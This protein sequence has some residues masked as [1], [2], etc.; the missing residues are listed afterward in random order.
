MYIKLIYA[1]MILALALTLIQCGGTED[2]TTEGDENSSSSEVE[3]AQTTTTGSTE[4]DSNSSDS[5]QKLESYLA[6]LEQGEADYGYYHDNDTVVFVYVAPPGVELESVYLV[7]NFTSEEPS[8]QTAMEQV[9]DETWIKSIAYETVV[10]NGAEEVIFDF[11][12]GEGTK[13]P[14]SKA[15]N[16]VHTSNDSGTSARFSERT[17]LS[18]A[19]KG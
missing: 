15:R 4:P 16:Q 8:D 9:D 1:T 11:V 7:G 14:I 5:N 12:D 13:L 6:A 10:E 2:T 3:P 17:G 18:F 19:T